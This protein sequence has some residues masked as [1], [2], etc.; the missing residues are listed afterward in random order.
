LRS[1][2]SNKNERK[3]FTGLKYIVNFNRIFSVTYFGVQFNKVKEDLSLVKKIVMVSWSIIFMA[4]STYNFYENLNSLA[5]AMSKNWIFNSSKSYVLYVVLIYGT[6]GYHIQSFVIQILLLLR[7]SK[8]INL[9]KNGL[10]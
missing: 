5:E 4:V 1:F 7:G 10:P 6:I 2:K 9:M 3:S 8:I